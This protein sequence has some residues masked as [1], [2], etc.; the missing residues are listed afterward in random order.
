MSVIHFHSSTTNK[1]N[2]EDQINQK[3]QSSQ[4]NLIN[5]ENQISQG[6]PIQEDKFIGGNQFIGGSQ[7]FRGNQSIGGNQFIAGN[8]FSQIDHKNE[9]KTNIKFEENVS[10]ISSTSQG[11]ITGQTKQTD[12]PKVEWQCEKE[13][14]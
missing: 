7:F 10:R 11:V 4:G 13:R 3:N 12:S 14:K 6:N 8:Q 2:Q 5:G 1:I 9:S